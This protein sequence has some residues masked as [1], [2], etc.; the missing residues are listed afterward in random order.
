MIFVVKS[1]SLNLKNPFA[2]FIIH[3]LFLKNLPSKNSPSKNLGYNNISIKFC[4]VF[5]RKKFK[6]GLESGLEIASE[7]FISNR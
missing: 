2:F 1:F 3:L 6:I 5:M 4:Q 7:R